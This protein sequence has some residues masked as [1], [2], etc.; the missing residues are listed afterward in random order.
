MLSSIIRR[1]GEE[2]GGWGY[3]PPGIGLTPNHEVCSIV[4]TRIRKREFAAFMAAF[5]SCGHACR[6]GVDRF[7]PATTGLMHRSKSC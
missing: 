1:M 4:L 3:T 5:A 6:V 2:L 7:V